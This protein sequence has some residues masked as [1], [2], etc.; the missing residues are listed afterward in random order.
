MHGITPKIKSF[1]DTLRLAAHLFNLDT[2]DANRIMAE[3]LRKL[4]LTKLSVVLYV[5]WAS[6]NALTYGELAEALGLTIKQV[7]AELRRL[8]NVFPHLFRSA[9]VL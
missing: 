2:F 4:G 5:N 3:N 6:H 9:P 1:D 7:K 8:R